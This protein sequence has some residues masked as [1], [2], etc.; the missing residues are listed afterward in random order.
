[1]SPNP[2]FKRDFFIGDGAGTFSIC[3]FGIIC[4]VVYFSS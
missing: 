4:G 2:A 3:Q 1:M